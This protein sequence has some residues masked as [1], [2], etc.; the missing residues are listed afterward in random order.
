MPPSWQISFVDALLAL[1]A[2]EAPHGLYGIRHAR[3]GDA[4][5]WPTFAEI[6]LFPKKNNFFTQ[7]GFVDI[8]SRARQN[9]LTFLIDPDHEVRLQALDHASTKVRRFGSS[10]RL[11]THHH[12]TKT[13]P[14]WDLEKL[15]PKLDGPDRYG[16]R[17]DSTVTRAI[18]LLAHAPTDR[19]LR[20]LTGRA[21]E[22]DFLRKYAV[23]LVSHEWKDRY[24][25]DFFSG[26]YLWAGKTQ[27]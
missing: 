11:D 25:R 18:L 8:G 6:L 12:K 3:A 4:E 22:E 16:H 17:R 7:F 23:T 5:R 27:A 13:E 14:E 1:D 19:Q 20:A 9:E 24:E 10:H 21:T 2:A 15:V 26:I